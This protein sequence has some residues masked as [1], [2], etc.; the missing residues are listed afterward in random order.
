MHR[1]AADGDLE[2]ASRLRCAIE[3]GFT[4][5]GNLTNK[6]LAESVEG[7]AIQYN[8]KGQI[9]SCADNGAPGSPVGALL[10]GVG[11]LKLGANV[12]FQGS[13]Q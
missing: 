1:L 2:A 9:R 11:A 3:M 12:L 7:S 6:V 10:N 8:S 4:A 5:L 13:S